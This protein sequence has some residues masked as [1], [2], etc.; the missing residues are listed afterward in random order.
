VSLETPQENEP[1]APPR[2]P[3]TQVL[4]EAPATAAILVACVVVFLLAERAGSTKD[5]ATLLR[6]GAV[7]R[8]EVWD[9]QYWRLATSMFLHIGVMH[10]FWNWWFGFK[11][12]SAAEAELGSW[13]FLA[14]YL[15]S[16]VVGAAVSVMGH[17]AVSAGASGALFGLIGW[18]LV[19]LRLQ[20]GSWRA[21]TQN[22]AIR[23]ELIWIGA[24]FV[25]GAFIGFDNFA[26]GGGM[27]FG[28]LFSWAL[29]TGAEP[30][31]VRR[32]RWATAVGVGLVLVAA[33]LRPL[34]VLHAAPLALRRAVASQSDP[35]AVLALT[36]PLLG[37]PRYRHRA[38]RL[39]AWALMQ[40]DRTG[41]AVDAA[42][43]VVDAQP[44]DARARVLRAFVLHHG[45]QHARAEADLNEAV[46]LDPSPW[47]KQA[48]EDLL[49]QPRR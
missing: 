20:I 23:R 33:S 31:P 15:G 7:S 12:C 38:L 10:L 46:Q 42:N 41:E 34:P 35:A 22:P 40:L 16:G 47:V 17:E 28:A 8:G 37:S 44:K 21:F 30:R 19:S 4:R 11:M 27:L 29:G 18:R 3:L 26:H 25:L 32:R 24:W 13:K 39:R 43:E 45:G 5:V 6:F 48:R 2:R 9:G 36:E 14:L 49:R 1:P